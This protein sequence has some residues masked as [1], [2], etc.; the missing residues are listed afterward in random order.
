VHPALS[1]ILFTTSHGAGYGLLALAGIL[2]PLGWLPQDRWFGFATLALALGAATLGLVASTF[3]LGHPERAWRAYTQWRSSWLSREGVLASLTYLPAGLFG[4]G[5]V[6]L[7]RL[8]GL[9]GACGVLA[10]ILAMVTVFATAMIYRSLRT[11]HQWSND[12]VPAIY[13]ANAVLSGAI[14]LNMLLLL[15]GKPWPNFA[16]F[17]A[18]AIAVGWLLKSAYWRFIDTPR[19]PST[20]GTAT[21][22][23]A[24]GEIRLFEAPHTH[25]NYLTEEMGYRAPPGR[26][27]ALRLFVHVALFAVPIALVAATALLPAAVGGAV[28][29]FVFVLSGAGILAERWLFMAE[30]KHTVM[31]YYGRQHA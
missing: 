7:G 14:W 24:Y 6:F 10:A 19:H 16:Y 23:S 30:A 25:D 11:I 4:I 29:V 21:S 9:W 18:F 17:T 27:R 5:W 3:H 31:L 13:L 15:F 20:A 2:G 12:W 1:V 22:L 28:M 26:L 8:D